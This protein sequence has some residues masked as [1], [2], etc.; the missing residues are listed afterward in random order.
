MPRP[1]TFFTTLNGITVLYDRMPGDYGERGIPLNFYATRE[2]EH[3]LDACF[4]ELQEVCPLGRPDLILSAGAWVEKPGYHGNGEAFDLDAIHWDDKKFVCDEFPSD[5]RFY[6]GVDAVLRKHIPTVLNYYYN[7]LHHDHLHV[8]MG[9]EM[10]FTRARSEVL[11]LQAALTHVLGIPVGRIDGD[12]GPNTAGGTERALTELGIGGSINDEAVWMEFLT[13]V[14]RRA[15]G[16][17]VLEAGVKTVT[18][19]RRTVGTRN[20]WM[21]RVDNGE[22]FLVGR[23]ASYPPQNGRGLSS[24]TGPRYEPD[25]YRAEYGFWADFIYPTAFCESVEGFFNALNTW[26]RAHFTFGFMQFGAHVFN[27]D[28]ARY[29][30]GLLELPDA[31]AYFPELELHD[32]LIHRRTA[33]GGLVNLETDTEPTPLARYL[34]PDFHVVEEVEAKNAARFIHWCNN[35]LA[36]RRLQVEVSVEEFRRILSSRA[37]TYGLNG[38]PDK[39]CLVIADIHHQG[40]GGSTTVTKIRTALDTGGDMERA[41][42]NLLTIGQANFESRITTLRSKISALTAAGILGVKKYDAG[43]NDFVDI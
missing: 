38:K 25:D 22:E 14:S 28:F 35:S 42:R 20:Q 16:E 7:D 3:R 1:D 13:A 27:G 39:V 43:T 10:G 36:N 8:D 11:F 18:V 26:D 6:L 41:Y 24:Y 31:S 12:W 23:E 37:A 2:I 5:S 34:N 19:R 33:G 17:Q 15:F 21:A 29:F 30:R 32:G 4:A 9:G 40:R